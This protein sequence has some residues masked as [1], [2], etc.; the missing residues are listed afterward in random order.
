MITLATLSLVSLVALA[1][2]EPPPLDAATT[3]D[4]TVRILD[5][6]AA[7]IGRYVPDALGVDLDGARKSWRGA[8]RKATVVALTSATCP[9][10]RKHAP[11]LARLEE[12]WSARGVEFVFVNVADDEVD[13]VREQR[14]HFGWRGRLLR[15]RDH[16]IVRAFAATTTTEVFIVD[17]SNTL[18]FRGAVSDQYA[19]GASL[20]APRRTFVEDALDALLAGRPIAVPATHAPGCAIEPPS[21]DETAAKDP[22]VTW[23]RDIVRILDA[24]CISCHHDGGVAPFPLVDYD[25]VERRG[26]MIARVVEAGTMPPWFAAKEKDAQRP[27]TAP[28]RFANDASLADWEKD[29]IRAWVAA[30]KPRGDDADLPADRAV[31]APGGWS[32]G[33]PDVVFEIPEP[34]PVKAEGTMPY[35]HVLVPTDFT[36]D[37]WV[38]GVQVLPTDRS[39]VHHVLVFVVPEARMKELAAE[40]RGRGGGRLGHDVDETSGFLAA[41]VPGNDASLLA[42]GYA[43]ALPKGSGLLFQI[44]YTPNGRATT[45]R[46]RLGLVFATERPRKVVETVGIAN[47]RISIPPGA[48]RHEE[49]ARLPVPFDAEILAFMPHMHVRGTAFRYE[50]E[51]GD[52]TREILLDIPRYDFDWQLR[53]LLRE[54]VAVVRGDVLHATAWYDNSEKNPANPD[55]AQTVRWGPQTTDEMMIG[56]I[57][58]VA[59]EPAAGPAD[60]RRAEVGRLDFDDLLRRHDRNEDGRIARDEV[61]RRQRGIFDRLDANDDG[62]VDRA[63]VDDRGP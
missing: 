32:I 21:I 2:V 55:P 35:Q 4:A 60:R 29:A 24:R 33:T 15:D 5:P 7:G 1:S 12:R 26:A 49:R 40:G 22:G 53:Y 50:V 19:I 17:G 44:H 3:V 59:K 39:V 36:E 6:H 18:V 20:D 54:P 48:A 41:Y 56:Y 62:F 46:T 28:S 34:I 63:E 25:D 42:E 16:A 51:R 8:G 9:L 13:A 11:G 23:A 31:P 10:S 47:P 52:G 30:G 43:K 45:D 14:S 37:R 38:R 27:H 57:E 61:P 58:F